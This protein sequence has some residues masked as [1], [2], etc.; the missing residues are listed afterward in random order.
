MIVLLCILFF[1]PLFTYLPMTAVAAIVIVAAARLIHFDFAFQWRIRAYREI[2]LT[3]LSFLSTFFLGPELGIVVALGVSLFLVVKHTTMPNLAIL[4]RTPSNKWRD[5]SLFASADS[6]P[7]VLVVRIDESLYFGNIEQIKDMI[8]R[9]ERLGDPHLHPSAASRNIVPVHGVVIDCKN[10]N[11]LDSIAITELLGMAADYKRR[12]IT[13]CLIHVR[14]EH[15]TSLEAAGLFS[16]VPPQ[17]FHSRI[18]AAVEQVQSIHAA[19]QRGPLARSSVGFRQSIRTTIIDDYE[20]PTST[21]HFE[22]PDD[23]L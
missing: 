6:I 2:V 20:G 22:T 4:G 11:T 10:V 21:R 16:H 5:I 8:S 17:N 18:S 14:L 9:I 15:L 3:V 13:F 23:D 7:G 1:M 12:D 19:K